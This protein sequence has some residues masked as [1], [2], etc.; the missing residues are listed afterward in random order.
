MANWFTTITDEQRTLIEEAPLFFVATA[1]PTLRPGKQGAGPVNM[2]P[3]GGVRLKVIASDRVAYL[4]Y[5]GSGSET[6]RHVEAGGPVTLMTC[7]F[8]EGDAAIVRLYGHGRVRPLA[9]C[10]YAAEL[11]RDAPEDARPRQVIEIDIEATMTSCGYGV[12]IMQFLRQRSPSERGERYKTR[13]RRGSGED[14]P[15]V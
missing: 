7:S 12:P 5:Q 9:S 10:D 3:K 15:R 13:G 4:D 11:F 6:A 2:S 8:A 14:A 1:D